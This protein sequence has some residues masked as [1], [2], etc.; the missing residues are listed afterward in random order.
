MSCLSHAALQGPELLENSTVRENEVTLLFKAFP[1]PQQSRYLAQT[2][3][4]IAIS[5]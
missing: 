3:T 2:I 1:F 4:Y 5:V